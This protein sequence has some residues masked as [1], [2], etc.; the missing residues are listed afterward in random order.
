MDG[1]QVEDE[2]MKYTFVSDYPEDDIHN[3]HWKRFLPGESVKLESLK[4]CQPRNADYLFSVAVKLSSC[5][6]ST[7]PEITFDQSQAFKDLVFH[8]LHI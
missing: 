3:I 6:K 8:P 5:Q 1:E 2:R 7:W 4:Q